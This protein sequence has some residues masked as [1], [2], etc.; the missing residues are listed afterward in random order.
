MNQKTEQILPVMLHKIYRELHNFG[1]RRRTLVH[2]NYRLIRLEIFLIYYYLL[3]NK[4]AIKVASHRKK[5]LKAKI[6]I[7]HF[8]FNSTGRNE[9]ALQEPV[10]CTGGNTVFG[11]VLFENF[12]SER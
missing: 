1:F 7:H 12:E 11:G 3:L 6:K 5:I 10:I 8:P 4:D 9:Y 2:K